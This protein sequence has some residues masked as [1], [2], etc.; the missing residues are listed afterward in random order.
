[1]LSNTHSGPA[2]CCPPPVLQNYCTAPTVV[3]CSSTSSLWPKWFLFMLTSHRI[4][5]PCKMMRHQI[6][7]EPYK[8]HL[9]FISAELRYFKWA[10]LLIQKQTFAKR[11]TTHKRSLINCQFSSH[12]IV[13]TITS[14]DRA[15]KIVRVAGM[16]RAQSLLSTEHL[17]YEAHFLLQI[18][19]SKR[20]ELPCVPKQSSLC[21]QSQIINTFQLGNLTMRFKSPFTRRDCLQPAGNRDVAAEGQSPQPTDG[22]QGGSTQQM[23]GARD[24]HILPF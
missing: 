10:C 16:S 23:V 6:I 19:S 11:S 8:V 17:H 12:I 24:S 20:Q 18:S 7:Q 15:H 21:K 5:L 4:L 14:T 1:M 9:L 22:K 2:T 13:V 3:I